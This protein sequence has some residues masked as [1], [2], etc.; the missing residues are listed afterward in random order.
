MRS[1]SLFLLTIFVCTVLAQGQGG[2]PM[3]TDDPSTPGNHN[4]EINTAYTAEVQERKSEYE[5][6]ILDMN[7]GWG[8]RIQLKLE[9]PWVVQREDGES[10]SGLG[11]TLLG[12]KWRFL[13]SKR[14]DLQVSTYPQLELNNPGYSVQRGLVERGPG[15]LLPLEVTKKAGPIELNVEGG[16]WF[17]RTPTRKWI[18]GFAVGHEVNH[19]LEL[20]SEKVQNHVNS[21]GP[22]WYRCKRVDFHDETATWELSQTG[23]Y[24]L[25][26]AYQKAPHRQLATATDDEQLRAFVKAWGPLRWSLDAWSGSDPIA[27]FRSE[28]DRLAAIVKVLASVAQPERQRDVLLDLV[29]LSA[30]DSVFEFILKGL[31]TIF[32]ILGECPPGFDPNIQ[33][34]IEG[35]TQNDI[36][37]ATEYLVCDLPLMNLGPSFTVVKENGQSVV[38]ASLGINTLGQALEWMVWQDVFQERRFQFCERCRRLFIPD[39]RHAMKFCNERCAHSEAARKYAQRKRDKEATNGT[40]KTR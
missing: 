24:S 27:N 32:P 13:D 8:E 33:P 18:A 19:R 4:W 25:L 15:F 35:A 21:D 29:R 10:H 36:Q 22:F 12:V 40:Q 11:N 26:E 16:Y 2:P 3:I 28:R 7:Y 38:R 23:R 34:W 39:S 20:L 14:L 9:L 6:P 30:R 17:Q 31:R 37:K 1:L 5:A